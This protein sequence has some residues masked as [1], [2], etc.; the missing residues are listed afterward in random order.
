[1]AKFKKDIDVSV[2]KF[3]FMKEKGFSLK[4]IGLLTF[5][6]GLPD[7]SVFTLKD[8]SE[9]FSDGITSIRNAVS[10]LEE[11][12]YFTRDQTRVNGKIDYIYIV[13]NYKQKKK[14]PIDILKN[15]SSIMDGEE[16]IKLI[17][18]LSNLRNEEFGE[19]LGVI[20]K[21]S[22]NQEFN[23]IDTIDDKDEIF[24]F[25]VENVKQG[26]KMISL[27]FI[28]SFIE[29][30]YSK[31][32]ILKAISIYSQTEGKNFP[33][34]ADL[35]FQEILIKYLSHNKAKIDKKQMFKIF[36]NLPKRRKK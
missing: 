1:M 20:S 17:D 32:E 30:G 29:D 2:S 19:T 21:E 25:Y 24:N 35:F 5:L 18:K 8:I 12:G 4:S 7:N 28:T 16:D 6:L 14:N 11:L 23:D 33:K 10:N 3:S 13:S 26:S 22:K 27:K 31:K 34:R 15:N 36:F 9:H